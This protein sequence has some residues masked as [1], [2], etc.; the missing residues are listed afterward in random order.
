MD[1]A[2]AGDSDSNLQAFWMLSFW[3]LGISLHDVITRQNKGQSNWNDEIS[4]VEG[5]RMAEL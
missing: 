1:L 2:S 3:K 5:L 4:A